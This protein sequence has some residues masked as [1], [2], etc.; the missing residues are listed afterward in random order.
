MAKAKQLFPLTMRP[1]IRRDGSPFQAE[2]CIN[3]DWVRWQKGMPRSMNGIITPRGGFSRTLVDISGM[4]AISGP[5]Q[6]IWV[7]AGSATRIYASGV[8]SNAGLNDDLT[9]AP[10]AVPIVENVGDLTSI[11][12]QP[13]ILK[14]NNVEWLLFYGCPNGDSTSATYGQSVNYA[15][16]LGNDDAGFTAPMAKN[17]LKGVDGL[18]DI[19]G[20]AVFAAP[21]LFL[22]GT[23]GTVRISRAV[24]CFDFRT[25][26]A[27]IKREDG[28]AAAVTVVPAQVQQL[29]TSDKIVYGAPIRGGSNS[30]TLLF[31]TLSALIRLSNTSTTDPLTNVQIFKAD[32]VS[33]SISILSPKCVVEYDGLFFWLGTDRFYVY[34]GNVSEIPNTVSIDYFFKTLDPTRAALT[35]GVKMPRYGE[36]WWFYPRKGDD[37]RLGCN[38]VLIYNKRENSWYDATLPAHAAFYAPFLGRVLSIGVD[39]VPTTSPMNDIPYLWFQDSPRRG[40]IT[41]D[42]VPYTSPIPAFFTTPYFSFAAFNPLKQ[43]VGEDNQTTINRLEPCFISPDGLPTTIQVGVNTLRYPQSTPVTINVDNIL[44]NVADEIKGQD[45]VIITTT[46]RIDMAIQGGNINITFSSNGLFE[47][48]HS[49]ILISLGDGNR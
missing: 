26:V 30:P 3:G 46:Q 15:R 42:E 12:W 47:M 23:N 22:Y 5:A 9:Y 24:D 14:R 18:R 32:P 25:D 49:S 13:L 43:Q 36:I 19:D 20:G 48:G 10:F 31:W 7:F 17:Q 37:P 40:Q 8:V 21:Y 28:I 27:Q 45:P 16:I 4:I 34:N 33:T 11:L 41:P 6:K 39:K 1:G 35:F 44:L 38:G 29:T 2:Y